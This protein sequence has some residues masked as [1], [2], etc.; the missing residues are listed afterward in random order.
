[1]F[2]QIDAEAQCAMCKNIV[3]S[4]L[5]NKDGGQKFGNGINTGILYLM[6]IPYFIVAT[7][8]VVFF[9]KQIIEK[10]KLLLRKV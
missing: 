6:G 9:K 10:A 3:K 4:N 1:M 8:V 2:S 7:I 5:E